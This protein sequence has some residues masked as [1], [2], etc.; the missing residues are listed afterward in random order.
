MSSN[1]APTAGPVRTCTR[2]CY[3]GPVRIA[4][5]SGP[6]GASL[7][8]VVCG[9]SL[10]W[11]RKGERTAAE[12]AARQAYFRQKA[13]EQ[14]PATPAQLAFLRALRDPEPPPENRWEAMQRITQLVQ[15]QHKESRPHE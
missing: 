1:G 9:Q 12:H 2:C 10:G 13:L 6:H 15:Q 14:K 5:G 7:W 4:A 8:C 3:K 11:Q